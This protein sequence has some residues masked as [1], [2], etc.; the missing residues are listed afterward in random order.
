DRKWKLYRRKDAPLAPLGAMTLP[1]LAHAGGHRH[2]R[3]TAFDARQRKTNVR[4]L[5]ERLLL[6]DY[7]P[8][9]VAV[10]EQGEILY[11]HGRSGKFLEL[12]SGEANLNLLR[13]ARD[14]LRVELAN[15]LRK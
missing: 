1:Q 5:T 7:S 13:V 15:A 8:A 3:G 14:G 2:E 10:N 6:R 4:E 11:I 12:P 9:C